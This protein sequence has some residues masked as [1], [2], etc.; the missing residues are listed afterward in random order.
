MKHK[1]K[2]TILFLCLILI[3]GIFMGTFASAADTTMLPQCVS[4]ADAPVI[5]G[6]QWGCYETCVYD[7]CN[8]RSRVFGMCKF[9][10]W[11]RCPLW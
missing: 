2:H 8:E 4:S 7:H 3:A 1:L 11:T 10:C 5:Q 6:Y 9:L